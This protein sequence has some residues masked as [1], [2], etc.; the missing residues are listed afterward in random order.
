[1]CV[2]ER[3]QKERKANSFKLSGNKATQKTE[4]QNNESRDDDDDDDDEEG[5]SRKLAK[6]EIFKY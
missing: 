3:K 6:M 5:K 1:M 2:R 4:N